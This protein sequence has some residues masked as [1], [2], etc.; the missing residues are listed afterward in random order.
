M[1]ARGRPLLVVSDDGTELKSLAILGW[2]QQHDVD[3]H[4]IA[5]GRPQQSGSVE[6]FIGRLR[7]ECLNQ[8]RSV[9]WPMRDRSWPPGAT[10]IASCDRMALATV[11]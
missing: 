9:A 8:T 3:R 1:T 4:S 10:T 7:D 5:P 11:K 6:S 2:R